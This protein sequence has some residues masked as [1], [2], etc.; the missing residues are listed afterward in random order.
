MDGS[1]GVRILPRRVAVAALAFPRGLVLCRAALCRHEFLGYLINRF[2]VAAPKEFMMKLSRDDLQALL[3]FRLAL[4]ELRASTFVLSA[5]V[6][7]CAPSQRS[8]APTLYKR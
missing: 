3:Y 5:R 8:V 2:I 7:S 4:G 6:A 1:A